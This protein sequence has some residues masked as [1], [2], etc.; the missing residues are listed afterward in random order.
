MFDCPSVRGVSDAAVF[1]RF[2]LIE[3]QFCRE[4]TVDDVIIR[5]K[6]YVRDDDVPII[7]DFGFVLFEFAA[8]F[9]S[10]RKISHKTLKT[11][12]G[13]LSFQQVFASCFQNLC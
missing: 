2:D 12:F 8:F 10:T 6:R 7:N 11:Y 9:F 3:F 1:I 5:P 13:T 4:S